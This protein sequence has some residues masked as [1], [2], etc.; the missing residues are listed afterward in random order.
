MCGM[1]LSWAAHA[2]AGKS[3][4]IEQVKSHYGE[5]D[6]N[7]DNTLSVNEV[8]LALGNPAIQGEEAAAV[9]SLR[10]GMLGKGI[11]TLTLEQLIA[12][13]PYDSKI[14]PAPPQYDSMYEASLTKINGAKRELFATGEP[15]LDALGQGRLGDCF[16]LAALGT[17][18]NHDPQ[19]L[20]K[21]MQVQPDGQ[22][23]VTFGTGERVV[24]PAPTDGEVVIGALTRNQG[25][26]A[27][28]FEKSVGRV[29]LEGQKAPRFVAPY[30]IIGVGGSPHTVLQL[31]T[32]HKVVRV[33][34]EGIRKPGLDAATREARLGEL[35]AKLIETQDAGRMMVAGNG[36]IGEQDAVTVPGIYYLHSY[37]VLNYDTKDDTVTFWNPFGNAYT[38]KGEPGLKTGYLTRYGR[39]TVPLTEVVQW[40]G[41]FSVESDQPLDG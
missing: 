29:F 19:G 15:E 39:F 3:G 9:A 24:L 18:V 5:W 38:P 36:A 8:E 7:H 16:L 4:F 6:T 22:V 34:C 1:A 14:T 26:W 41:S 2:E 11:K 30:S 32:G 10:R 17:Y 31:V 12:S 23:A 28:M 40:L 33:G 35:R 21:M 20:K 27:N 37:A 13:V 25:T